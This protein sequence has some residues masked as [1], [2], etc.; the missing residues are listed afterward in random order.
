MTS[1]PRKWEKLSYLVRALVLVLAVSRLGGAQLQRQ[2]SP[3]TPLPRRVAAT[4]QQGWAYFHGGR[5]DEADS[6]FAIAR[7]AC[8][9]DLGALDGSAYVALRRGQLERARAAFDSLLAQRPNDYDGLTGSGIVGFRMGDTSTARTRFERAAILFPRDSTVRAYLATLL[10]HLENT[11]FA[12]VVRPSRLRVAAR[13]GPRRFEVPLSGGRWSPFWIKGVNIGA[14]LPGKHP[15]DFPRDDGTYESWIALVARMGANTVRLYTIHPPHFYRALDRW[16]RAHPKHPLWLIHGVWT[17]LPP[18]KEQEQYDDSTWRAAFRVEGRRVVDLL[19]GHA[20][21]KPR[22]GHASGV[23]RP[24]VSRWVLAY[25]T[26]R[27]WE[28]YS[29]VAYSALNPRKISYHGRF[30][31]VPNGNAP[32]VWLGEESD[33]LVSYEVDTY[34]AIRP[35]AYTNWPTLDA[36]H[37]PTESTQQEENKL[38]RWT[39]AEPSLEFDNDAIALDATHMRATSGNPAGTF[40]SFH[41]YPYY[42]DFMLLDPE[43]AKARSPEGAS[44]YYG[45]LSALVAHHGEMPVV[46]SEYGVPSSRGVAHVQPQGWNHGGHSEAAQASI[47][48]RLTREIHASGAAGAMLFSVIDEWFKKNWIVTDFEQPMER[49]RLWLNVLDPEQSYGILAMRAG[50]KDAALTIDGQGSDW[51]DRGRSWSTLPSVATR[52]DPLAIHDFRVW[53]DEAYLYL[54]LD[55]N[56]IDWARGRYMIAIDTHGRQLGGRAL[57]HTGASCT[58]GFEFVVDLP[59]P[60]DAQLLVDRPYNLYRAAPLPGSDPPQVMQIYNG[61]WESVAHD[62]AQWDTLVVETNRSRVGRDGTVYPRVVYQRNRLLFARQ[63]TSTLA[64]WFADSSTGT[65]EIRLGWGMLEVLDPS[66]RTVLQGT[67]TDKHSPAGVVTDG[68]RFAVAS[69]DPQSPTNGG[70]VLGCEREAPFFYTWAPWEIP[71]WHQEL[72]PLFGAMKR[73]F[74][75]ITGPVRRVEQ[76]R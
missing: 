20:V 15:S 28:P 51:G 31:E 41:A 33:A 48:A 24:D 6:S 2:L 56:T 42:P 5:V 3:C 29:V 11:K 36:L 16:N 66:S 8:P 1:S 4:I 19:H 61:P 67:A 46:I 49:N 37:H 50:T 12:A 71:R 55:V 10:P 27:E 45:Y 40:A 9:R 69:Y 21:I 68:F 32:E 72:K 43:Y 58:T 22:A 63:A 47:D 52:H 44:A 64:D 13:T 35:I 14:A 62:D 18:G 17:E 30:V 76:P 70:M 38:R 73:T 26:G 74:E 34:N 65:I 23:Y 25:I 75:G 7:Q 57:P 53:S 54:R 59:S 60:N 39:L